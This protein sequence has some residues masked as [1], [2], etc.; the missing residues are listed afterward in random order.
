MINFNLFF[1]NKFTVF[2]L[3][4]EFSMLE[5]KANVMNIIDLELNDFNLFLCGFGYVENSLDLP[6]ACFEFGR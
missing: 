4:E 6:L 3:T 5:V 1:S 2:S